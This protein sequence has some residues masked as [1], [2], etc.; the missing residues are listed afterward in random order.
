MNWYLQSGKQSDV[1]CNTKIEYSRNFR[2]YKFQTNNK[3]EIEQIENEIKSKLPSLG[4]GLKFCKLKDMD[5]LTKSSLVEK[6]LINKNMAKD[7]NE[8]YSILVNDEENICIMLNEEDHI[9]LQVFSAGM[10]LENNFNYA[11]EIDEKIESLFDIAKSEKYGYLTTVPTK[12]GTRFNCKSK[13][14]FTRT[15]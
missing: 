15:Y 14:T 5:N 6:G 2:N 4:Y 3:S 12:V 1:V 10:D 13:A 8:V 11:K 9:E 7:K